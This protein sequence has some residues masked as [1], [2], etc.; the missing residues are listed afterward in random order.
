MGDT[1]GGQTITAIWSGSD[2]IGTGW[3]EPKWAYFGD[4]VEKVVFTDGFAAMKP[5]SLN[6]WFMNFTNMTTIEGMENLNTSEVTTMNSAFYECEKLTRL[7]LDNFEVSKLRNTATMFAGCD[8]LETIFCGKSWEV[9]S[10]GSMFNSCYK[11]KGAVAYNHSET[12]CTMAN[13]QNGY[14]TKKEMTLKNDEDNTDEIAKFDGIKDVKVT[15]DGRS[16]AR[17]GKWNTVVLPFDLTIAGSPF[18]HD[19][20]TA[21]ELDVVNVYDGMQTGFDS[22]TGTLYLYFKES[23]N[24]LKAGVPYIIK[25]DAA[26]TNISGPVFTDVT[27]NAKAIEPVKSQDGKVQF[28]GSYKPVEFT[29][30]DKETLYL[31]SSNNLIYPNAAVTMKSLRAYFHVDL[32]GGTAQIKSAVMNFGAEPTAIK[33]VDDEQPTSTDG[34]WYTVDGTKLS[35]KTTAKGVYIHNGVKVV[36]K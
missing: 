25:W 9:A 19:G 18:A 11:L 10:S 24:E 28:R 1:Y 34:A 13:P 35:G 30:N 27:I 26:D 15:L 32:N 2:V 14:F 3:S 6:R 20:V 4:K 17:T 7:D 8:N 22:S 29:A 12:S 16:F 31:G 23:T 33:L 21:R 36:V 5:N